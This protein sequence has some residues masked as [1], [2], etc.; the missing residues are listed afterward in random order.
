MPA[1]RPI[2][3]RVDGR[4]FARAVEPRPPRHQVHC[5]DDVRK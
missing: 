1:N 2:R 4:V 3:L 5:V